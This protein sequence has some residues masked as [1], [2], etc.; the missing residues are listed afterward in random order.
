MIGYSWASSN[1]LIGALFS[2]SRTV[3]YLGAC[4]AMFIVSWDTLSSIASTSVTVLLFYCLIID[5]RSLLRLSLESMRELGEAAYSSSE[6]KAWLWLL[7]KYGG[8][9]E[10]MDLSSLSAVLGSSAAS[11]SVIILASSSGASV[12]CFKVFC[13]VAGIFKY[14]MRFLNKY[15]YFLEYI[16]KSSL[17]LALRASSAS[18]PA[19]LRSSVLGVY[20]YI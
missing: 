1:C 7:N 13:G 10:S 8:G 14:C 3:T 11:S 18:F 4:G 15:W 9:L 20:I 2:V 12:Y 16:E 5:L 19:A 17:S 6:L